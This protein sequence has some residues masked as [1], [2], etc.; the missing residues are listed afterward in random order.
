MFVVYLGIG[1]VDV[2]DF[3]VGNDVCYFEFEC[4]LLRIGCRKMWV[5]CNWML[6]WEC[7]IGR[8]GINVDC[9]LMMRR[10]EK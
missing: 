5:W 9:G 2:E 8:E 7:G 6:E 4:K 3:G 1:S 10:G